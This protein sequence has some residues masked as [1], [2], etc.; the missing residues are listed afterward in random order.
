MHKKLII[1]CL[2]IAAF[3]A[4]VVTPGA[5]ATSLGEGT[6]VVPSGTAIT[7][8]STELK[9]TAGGNTVTCTTAD[10]IGTVT[11]NSGGTLATET[12]PANTSFSG[13]GSGGDCTSE[14]L[15]PVKL[16]VNSKLCLHIAKSIDT[17]TITGCAG[18]VVTFTLD[19]TNLFNLNCRY[20]AVALTGKI[21][22]A[23]EGKDAEVNL[24]EQPLAGEAG[25]SPFCPASG[26]LDMEF[27]LTTAASGATLTFN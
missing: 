6:T 16:T 7:G 22:T 5:L 15:G 20:E 3:A 13:T 21:T 8:K 27:K 2:A 12:L 24:F 10:L 1:A 17:G 14:G 23:S 11:F 26:K 18:A 9:F 19:I 4:F 25:N